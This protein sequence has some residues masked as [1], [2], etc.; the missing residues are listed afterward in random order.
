MG[1]GFPKAQKVNRGNTNYRESDLC[2]GGNKKPIAVGGKD[3]SVST[4]MIISPNANPHNRHDGNGSYN[5]QNS[6]E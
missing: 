3:N 5:T 2:D 1:V 4:T 6:A